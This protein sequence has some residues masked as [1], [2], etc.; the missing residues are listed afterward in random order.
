MVIAVRPQEMLLLSAR[1]CAQRG[2]ELG[3]AAVLTAT[4]SVLKMKI[5]QHMQQQQQHDES[6]WAVGVAH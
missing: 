1:P 4:L 5:N 2:L 6:A 3:L